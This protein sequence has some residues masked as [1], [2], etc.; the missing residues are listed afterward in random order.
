[1]YMYVSIK[2]IRPHQCCRDVLDLWVGMNGRRATLNVLKDALVGCKHQ[3]VV[4]I[5]EGKDAI[6]GA[7]RRHHGDY[8]P[9]DSNVTD[10]RRVFLLIKEKLGVRWK[11][12]A[13]TL[14][15]DEATI[16]V[17]TYK[18]RDPRDAC[19]DM[20]EDWRQNKGRGATL[21][22]LKEALETAG[23]MDVVDAI[24]EHEEEFKI[25]R[26]RGS[27]PR[28]AQMSR[29]PEQKRVFISYTVDPDTD[30]HR[31]QRQRDSRIALQRERVRA[32]SDSL[33]TNGVDSVIDQYLEQNPPHIWP[34]WTEDEIH[35][36]DYVLMICTPNYLECVTGRKDEEATSEYKVRFEGKVIYAKLADPKVHEKFLPVF[37]DEINRDNVPTV[38]QG[39]H[40]YGPIDR[41]PRYGQDTFNQL[42]YKIVGSAPK[43]KLPPPVGN[44]PSGLVP[45]PR[46]T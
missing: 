14:D 2:V 28:A 1:M 6:G 44:I 29:N 26:R 25:K 43:E 19:M 22:V 8:G 39:G 21:E 24:I 13:R 12:F 36:A 46:R 9:Y 18:H 20:L 35:M 15:F 38:F 37:F 32:L 34:R 16:D 33:R 11:D 42:F 45:V 4:D 23:R 40:F 3:D 41:N 17:F 5:I 10:M 7:R 30:P 27:A 31:T